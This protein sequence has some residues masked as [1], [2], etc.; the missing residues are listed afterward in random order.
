MTEPEIVSFIPVLLLQLVRWGLH[1]PDTTDRLNAKNRVFH[2][3][4]SR[5]KR[6]GG[7]I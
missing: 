1:P 2:F 7:L 6:H 3:D 4:L 5:P